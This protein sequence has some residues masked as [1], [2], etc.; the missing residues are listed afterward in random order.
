MEVQPDLRLARNLVSRRVALKIC[1]LAIAVI[2]F[3]PA[4]SLAESKPLLNLENRISIEEVNRDIEERSTPPDGR[5]SFYFGFD[6]RSGPLEDA[7][8]YL[9][10]LDYLG[11]STGYSFKLR[12]T[13]KNSSITDDLGTGKVHFAAVGAV[14]FIRAH[15]E[16]GVVS[17]ARG[18]N[19]LGKSEYQS[20]IVVSPESHIQSLGDLKG[21]RLAFGAATSTQGHLIPRIVLA[22][23]G[24][25]L[26]DLAAYEYT[27]SH[28]NCANAV[29]KGAF[30]ACGMQDTMANIMAREGLLRILHT[31]RYY[32]SSGIAVNKDVPSVVFEKVRRALL[33]FD[34]LGRDKNDLYDWQKTEMPN[35]FQAANATDYAELRSWLAWLEPLK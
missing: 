20:V 26:G 25:D 22:E 17:L 33:D 15:D 28:R 23:N 35:G 8:Q 11:R 7:R 6:L 34:P 4:Q 29:I 1:F 5:K 30:D 19:S 18:V 32:P 10:F 3:L 21:G 31:S 24:I 13:P 14:S 12:F 27:G 2:S 9:P 16:Y